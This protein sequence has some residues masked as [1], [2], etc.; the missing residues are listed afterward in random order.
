[1]LFCTL[2][3]SRFLSRV[4]S[5]G[6]CSYDRAVGIT[7]F[8]V[9]RQGTGGRE[10]PRSEDAVVCL[11]LTQLH[12]S[13][14]RRHF[15]MPGDLVIKSDGHVVRSALRIGINSTVLEFL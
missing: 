6:L 9:P 5:K 15:V 14:R 3:H 4:V 1:M 13:L 8:A 7:S 12:V 11:H 10:K 2:I